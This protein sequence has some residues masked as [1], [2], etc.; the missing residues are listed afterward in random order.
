MRR[1]IR[2]TLVGPLGIASAALGASLWGTA[3]AAPRAIAPSELTYATH[4]EGMKKSTTDWHAEVA[5]SA[6]PGWYTFQIESAAAPTCWYAHG[7]DA[8]VWP[9]GESFAGRADGVVDVLGTGSQLVF[10]CA[11]GHGLGPM[12]VTLTPTT[13]QGNP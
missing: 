13:M 10:K 8:R 2:L 7:S 4:T 9:G 11:N 12:W 3:G 6:A 5:F 1:P